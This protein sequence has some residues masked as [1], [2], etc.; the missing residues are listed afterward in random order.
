MY[1]PPTPSQTPLP[2]LS[3]NFLICNMRGQDKT[4][5]WL[6]AQ[7]LESAMPSFCQNLNL[8]RCFP[9][10]S[11]LGVCSWVLPLPS[12]LCPSNF[13]AYMEAV[14]GPLIFSPQTLGYSTPLCLL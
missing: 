2:S 11:P 1:I 7:M 10:P 9:L 13:Q 6:P 12:D 14:L 3:L 5:L 8:F 4:G